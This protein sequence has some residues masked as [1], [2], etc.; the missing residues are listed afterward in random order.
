MAV[1]SVNTTVAQD[2]ALD[3]LLV[4]ENA[5]RAAA[6]LPS[7]T[8]AQFVDLIF[9]LTCLDRVNQARAIKQQDR[10]SAYLSASAATAASADSILG[11]S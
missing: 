6:S 10:I 5:R 7:I 9:D 2:T 3:Y 8:K 4:K 1:Y 11:V